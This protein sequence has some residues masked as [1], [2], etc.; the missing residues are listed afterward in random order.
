VVDRDLNIPVTYDVEE[1]SAPYGAADVRFVGDDVTALAPSYGIVVTTLND[2][3]WQ[4]EVFGGRDTLNRIVSGPDSEHLVLVAGGVGYVVPVDT[5]EDYAVVPV[6]PVAD[7]V[8][9]RDSG[10]VICVGLTK[11][12]AV[13]AGGTVLWVS[14]QVT[15]DGIAS[16]RVTSSLIVVTG[17]DAPLNRQVETTL[18]L[19][20]GEVTGS[21]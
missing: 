8:V 2:L 1:V 15:A 4:G 9:V 12:A 16:V 21:M 11:I 13:G 18:D 3:R 7:V 19:Q 14:P 20:S 6:R 17:W 10:L 5:P